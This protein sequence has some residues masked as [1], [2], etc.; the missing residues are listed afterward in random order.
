MRTYIKIPIGYMFSLPMVKMQFGVYPAYARYSIR[1]TLPESNDYDIDL[2]GFALGG[3]VNIYHFTGLIG[4]GGG[5]FAD[6]APSLRGIYNPD[7]NISSSVYPSPWVF[8]NEDNEGL[9]Q[10]WGW[11]EDIFG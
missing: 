3:F 4:F 2:N 5:L 10:I 6:Y 1:D 7:P 8:L 9:Y 11:G